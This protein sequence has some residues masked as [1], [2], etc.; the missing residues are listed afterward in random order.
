MEILEY[1][2]IIEKT[3]IYPKKVDGFGIAYAY[4]GI[5]GENSEYMVELEKMQWGES[6]REAFVKEAGDVMW[7]ITLMSTELKLNLSS[8]YNDTCKEDTSLDSLAEPIKKHYRDNKPIDSDLF[9]N[10]LRTIVCKMKD[11]IEFINSLSN[12]NISMS[13]ILSTNYAK[14]LKR[15]ENNTIKGDGSNR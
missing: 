1:Q 14:L 5:I 7:Y 3:A 10:A 2:T 6:D 8:I 11:D 15:R 13:E 4:L 9:T 12:H